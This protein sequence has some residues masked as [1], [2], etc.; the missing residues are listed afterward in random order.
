[1]TLDHAVELT[2]HSLMLALLIAAPILVVGLVVGLV[3]SLLQAVTQLQEQTLS[4]IPKIVAMAVCAVL[5]MPW[6]GQHLIEYARQVFSE[7]AIR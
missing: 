7:G 3:T 6:M 5:L 2:R 1:M 4:F